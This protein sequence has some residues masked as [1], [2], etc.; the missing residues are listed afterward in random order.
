MINNAVIMGRITHDLEVKQTQGGKSVLRFNVAVDRPTK[1]GQEKQTDFISCVAW[2]GQADFIRKYFGKG[3]MIALVGSI[4]TGSYTDKNNVKRYTTEIW[5]DN[6]SF[7]G[8]PGNQQSNQQNNAQ[9]GGNALQY[10]QYQQNANG[11][12]PPQNTQNGYQNMPNGG[13]YNQQG[14][15]APQYDGYNQQYGGNGYGYGN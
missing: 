1:Q 9:Q 11:N 2:N 12:M 4:R 3:R 13:G 8:E 5:V 15:Y 6:V 10:P 14:G 7:T